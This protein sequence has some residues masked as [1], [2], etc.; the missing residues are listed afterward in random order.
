[1][2]PAPT[3]QQVRQGFASG[4][5]FE[6]L[7]VDHAQT[8]HADACLGR[9]ALSLTTRITLKRN[10]PPYLVLFVVG[11]EHPMRH[12]R[13]GATTAAADIIEGGRANGNTRG[14][15]TFRGSFG[16]GSL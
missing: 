1:M 16:H 13:H 12:F 6:L 10:A 7:L 8:R 14:I 9:C 4:S 15:R 11:H 5:W 2:R 3:Q